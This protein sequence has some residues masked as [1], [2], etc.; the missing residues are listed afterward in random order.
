[1]M[2]IYN[3]VDFSDPLGQCFAPVL[4]GPCI[5]PPLG[6]YIFLSQK[7]RNTPEIFLKVIMEHTS[8]EGRIPRRLKKEKSICPGWLNGPRAIEGVLTWSGVE[9]SF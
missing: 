5:L 7:I 8:V 3:K 6:F 1:M 9:D 2:I 4:P